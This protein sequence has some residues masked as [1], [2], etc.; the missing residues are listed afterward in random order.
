[1]PLSFTYGKHNFKKNDLPLVLYDI[2]NNLTNWSESFTF[3]IELSLRKYNEL[4]KI[5]KYFPQNN[6]FYKCKTHSLHPH[7]LAALY[8]IFTI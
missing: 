4:D 5:Q 2:K 3:D 1:M 7:T 8:V 6:Y